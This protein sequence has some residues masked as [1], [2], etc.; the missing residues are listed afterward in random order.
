MKNG[1]RVQEETTRREA[2]KRGEAIISH[3]VRHLIT[4]GQPIYYG[5]V[6]STVARTG[7]LD[8]LCAQRYGSVIATFL[9]SLLMLVN[10]I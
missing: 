3:R 5:Q 6:K 7:Y 9:V 8:I 4:S 10:S 1:P 2:E